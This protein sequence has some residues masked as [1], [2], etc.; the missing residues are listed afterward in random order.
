MCEQIIPMIYH[1][2]LFYT[3]CD[4]KAWT[5]PLITLYYLN[6]IT[7]FIEFIDTVFLVVKQKKL[8]FYIL[9]IMELLLY[10]VILN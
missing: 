1:H 3:I 2:G 8:T 6:Y 10:Y 7:K 4:I 5:Q 9:I